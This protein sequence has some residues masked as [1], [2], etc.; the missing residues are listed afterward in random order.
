MWFGTYLSMARLLVLSRGDASFQLG[1][2]YKIGFQWFHSV[3]LI[4]IKRGLLDSIGHFIRSVSVFGLLGSYHYR[5]LSLD[6]RSR[7]VAS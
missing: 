1:L 5:P 3:L 7:G 4:K 2:S 6:W